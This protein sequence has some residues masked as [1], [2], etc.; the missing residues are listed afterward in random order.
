MRA[1]FGGFDVEPDPGDVRTSNAAEAVLSVQDLAVD[2]YTPHGPLRVVDGVTFVV[3]AGTIVGLV[4]ES[5]SG[6]TMTSL[7]VMGLI[8]GRLGEV[9]GSI[10]FEGRELALASERE[11]EDIRG[12][13]ISMIFQDPMTSLNPAFTVGNQIAEVLRRH[14]RVSRAAARA[15]SIDLL[16]RVGIPNST[17]AF[18]SFVHEFSGGM[19]QRAM[20]A[21][22]IACGPRL[23]VADEPTTALD[24]TVQAQVLNLLRRMRDEEGLSIL[25]VTHNLA[26]VA[27][28]CDEVIVMYAGQVME[29]TN[30]HTIFANPKHPYTLALLDSAP[31]IGEHPRGEFRAVSGRAPEPGQHGPGCRFA[32]RCSFAQPECNDPQSLEEIESGHWVRCRRADEIGLRGLYS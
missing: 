19:R 18:S 11:L 21:M 24:V 28:L 8:R 13:R 12:N 4:G 16:A 22:T 14:K 17:A 6:K 23:L 3:S 25:F 26:V 32:D 15:Q 2:L 5:G 7:S 9:A 20:I 30:V 10:S 31:T 29:R 27:E 1:E